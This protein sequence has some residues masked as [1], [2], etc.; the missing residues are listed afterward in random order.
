MVKV[1]REK[2]GR[3]ILGLLAGIVS[4]PMAIICWPIFVAVYLYNM[5]D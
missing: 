1:T 5:E 4:I 3:A 2:V